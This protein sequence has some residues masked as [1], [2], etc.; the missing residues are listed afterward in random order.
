MRYTVYRSYIV[1]YFECNF[2]RSREI[3]APS[4]REALGLAL[5]N[6][7]QVKP[8]TVEILLHGTGRVPSRRKFWSIIFFLRPASLQS[9]SGK[10]LVAR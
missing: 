7:F 9:E 5:I 6:I 2:V 10:I 3:C 4:C 8:R 1:L